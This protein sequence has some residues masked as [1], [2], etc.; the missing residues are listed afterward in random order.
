L[1]KKRSTRQ[2]QRWF[3]RGQGWRAGIEARISIL[4][5]PFGMKRAHYKGETGFD[6]YVGCCVIAQNLAAIVRT[7]IAKLK[8][9][10]YA[11]SG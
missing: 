6:R 3:R 5:H 11:P 7:K 4:K 9:E 8:K 1:S 10:R 2:K